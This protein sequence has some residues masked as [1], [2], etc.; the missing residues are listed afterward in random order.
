MLRISASNYSY[1]SSC[2]VGIFF[3]AL[4]QFWLKAIIDTTTDLY[5]G[6][7]ELKLVSSLESVDQLITY[8]TGPFICQS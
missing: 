5:G 4:K 8:T 2:E 7:Q 6:Q 3:G 1:M